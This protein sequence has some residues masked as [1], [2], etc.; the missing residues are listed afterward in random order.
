MRLRYLTQTIFSLNNNQGLHTL[1]SFRPADSIALLPRALRLHS[2]SLRSLKLCTLHSL[3]RSLGSLGLN[4]TSYSLQHS[5]FAPLHH[6]PAC[7][8][9]R[10]CTHILIRSAVQA[11]AGQPFYFSGM[12]MLGFGDMGQWSERVTVELQLLMT[13]RKHCSNF[14]QHNIKSYHY[15]FRAFKVKKCYSRFQFHVLN[16]CQ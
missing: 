8:R 15:P 1:R 14:L 2:R 3:S 12:N 6:H 5:R 11:D 13:C 9:N 16:C 7:D 10:T 4:C